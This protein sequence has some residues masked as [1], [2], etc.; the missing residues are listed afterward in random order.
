MKKI[1]YVAAD[2]HLRPTVWAHHPTMRGDTYDSF[3]QVIQI[4]LNDPDKLPLVLLGD[5]FDKSRPDSESVQVYLS[6]AEQLH[7]AN[8]PL[9]Y[10]QGNHDLADPAWPALASNAIS[11]HNNCV[12]I[13]GKRFVGLDYQRADQLETAVQN[14][15]QFRPFDY[16][17]VHQAWQELQGVGST[18]GAVTMFKS[19]D[20][21]LSGDLHI[22]MTR[23]INNVVAHSPGSTSMQS[24]TEARDKFVTL[25]CDSTDPDIQFSSVPLKTRGLLQQTILTVSGLA[26]TIQQIKAFAK[27]AGPNKP[28]VHVKYSPNVTDAFSKLTGECGELAYLFL[29]QLADIDGN[30][31]VN[32]DPTSADLTVNL[33]TAVTLLA[34]NH[35][36]F[37][38]VIAASLLD[39]TNVVTTIEKLKEDFHALAKAGSAKLL[40]PQKT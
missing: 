36:E 30:K 6:G 40:Q 21:V 28:L 24:I 1:A 16:V 31:I 38:A 35:S 34:Q 18:H 22:R 17:C 4:V 8:I 5:I 12:T 25:L 37:E 15:D 14:L 9:Y 29:N 33:R 26:T 3:K 27:S 39:A 13:N 7:A 20:T 23:A 11:L 32:I 19:G 10:I 2:L